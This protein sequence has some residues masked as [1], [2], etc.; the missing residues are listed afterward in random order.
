MKVAAE[1]VFVD[2][3]REGLL[4]DLA[5]GSLFHL[6]ESAAMVW[7]SSL[8]GRLPDAIADAMANRYHLARET[9]REHVAE[10]L[11]LDPNA[12]EAFS[13]SGPY[14]YQRSVHG[15]TLY[16]DGIALLNIDGDGR[17]V[18]L[19]R[20]GAVT[21]RELPFVLQAVAPKLMSLRG[22]FVM[23]A[24]AIAIG[25]GIVAFSGKS[26]SGK[27]T[28]ARALA[29]AGATLVCE[30][31]LVVEYSSG[32]LIGLLEGERAIMSWVAEAAP[33]MGNAEPATCD[34]LDL[35]AAGASLPIDAIG[36]L[37]SARRSGDSIVGFVLTPVQAT[38]AMFGNSFYGSDST[39]DWKRRLE[40]AAA[41]ARTLR[42]CE[43]TTP[44]SV[45]LLEV[46]AQHS[47]RRQVVL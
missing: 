13:P 16:R 33:K 7:E 14:L 28:T 25:S 15:Y 12:G 20:P 40:S 30:D 11:K 38:R 45:A 9:A 3:D 43:V 41:A 19:S 35:A 8:A 32:R 31:K 10:A 36:F 23:H 22:H 4:L 17:W 21:P 42:A 26:G 1:Y 18:S 24:S 44:E 47:V 39:D 46:A 2:F 5:S 29:R 27:T 34:G 6:N 37:D